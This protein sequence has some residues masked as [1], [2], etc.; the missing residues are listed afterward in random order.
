MTKE[1]WVSDL[2]LETSFPK[3]KKEGAIIK[4]KKA[5]SLIVSFAV[6]FTVVVTSLTVN[7]QEKSDLQI[8]RDRG[9]LRVGAA[10][11]NPFYMIEPGSKEWTGCIPDIMKLIAN[12]LNVKLEYV[13]TSWGTAA[14]GL[15]S[16]RFDIMGAF[17]ASPARALA[18]HFTREIHPIGFGVLTR[19]KQEIKYWTEV[20]QPKVRLAAVVGTS[21]TKLMEKHL[22]NVTWVRV[23]NHDALIMELEAGRSE[24][25]LINTFSAAKY[26]KSRGKGY[27]Y[28]PLPKRESDTNL[29]VRQSNPPELLRWLNVTLRWLEQQG[30]IE[31]TGTSGWSP[32]LRSSSLRFC[33]CN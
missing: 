20:D 27:Y 16:G 26:I 3:K 7:A 5:F 28:E 25:A 32:Q 14:A 11:A 24:I 23:Q 12:Q 2:S 15:Q 13:E 9:V 19:K 17:N 21:L 33:H 10:V 6:V 22:T 8:I 4:S 31:R 18:V 1:T 30:D 29:A